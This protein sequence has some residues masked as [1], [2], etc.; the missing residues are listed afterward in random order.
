MN[1]QT[2]APGMVF[3]SGDELLSSFREGSR[4]THAVPVPSEVPR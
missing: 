4:P 2:L 1:R 3:Q